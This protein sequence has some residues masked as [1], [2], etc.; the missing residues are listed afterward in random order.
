MVQ[1]ARRS[2]SQ[3]FVRRCRRVDEALARHGTVGTIPLDNPTKH[4][5]KNIL[6]I[7]TLFA[8][9]T[10]LNV[11]CTAS[12]GIH[13]SDATKLNTTTQVAYVSAPVKAPSADSK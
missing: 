8:V 11:G 4:T 3:D 5:M 7:S 9:A 2:P 1:V 13:K 10:L 12:A 6:T